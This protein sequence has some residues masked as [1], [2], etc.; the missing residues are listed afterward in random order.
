MRVTVIPIEIG[1]HVSFLKGFGE[2][3]AELKTRGRI[4]TI[5]PTALLRPARILRRGLD[6]WENALFQTPVKGHQ[7]ITLEWKTYK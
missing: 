7:L 4:E 5:Q 2:G 1:A 3:L 6:N